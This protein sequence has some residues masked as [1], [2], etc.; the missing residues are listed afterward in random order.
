M[1]VTDAHDV[2]RVSVLK[3]T[4][5]IEAVIDPAFDAGGNYRL[6]QAALVLCI[7]DE[8]YAEIARMR[9]R[10]AGLS[11]APAKKSLEPMA[12][13]HDI[14]RSPFPLRVEEPEEINCVE[15]LKQAG[16]VDASISPAL[17]WKDSPTPRELAIV[18]RITP[19][20]RAALARGR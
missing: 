3:A 17:N 14:E 1:H 11:S 9:G 12:Y 2:R 18:R 20:G 16:F 15:A 13:L 5:L 10:D 6:A 4:S 7:T 8:G 19:F